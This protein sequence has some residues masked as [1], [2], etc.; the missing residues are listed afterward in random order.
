[1]NFNFKLLIPAILFLCNNTFV[2]LSVLSFYMVVL[3][4]FV[5][6]NFPQDF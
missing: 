6:N 1:M 5:L 4:V 3:V 2:T